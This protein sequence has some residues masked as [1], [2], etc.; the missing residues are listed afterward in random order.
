M[1]VVRVEASWK[2]VK[3][4]CERGWFLAGEGEE[5]KFKTGEGLPWLRGCREK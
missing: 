5:K 1:A 4:V 2:K 3:V